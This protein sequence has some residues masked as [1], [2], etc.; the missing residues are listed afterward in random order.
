[1]PGYEGLFEVREIV[2]QSSE[3]ALDLG[4]RFAPEDGIEIVPTSDAH[5]LVDYLLSRKKNAPLAGSTGDVEGDG[6]AG[7]GAG[8]ASAE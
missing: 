5:A 2:G 1:M 4:E 6:A 8:S 3:N 7:D